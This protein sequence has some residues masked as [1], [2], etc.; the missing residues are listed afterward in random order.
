[1]S[2]D[3]TDT[4]GDPMGA[5]FS[6]NFVVR[7]GVWSTP[8]ELTGGAGAELPRVGADPQGNAVAVWRAFDDTLGNSVLA[9]SFTSAQ[10]WTTPEPLDNL[11]GEPIFDEPPVLLSTGGD[12]VAAWAQLL[13]ASRNIYTNRLSGGA[14]GGPSLRSDG[15]DYSRHTP[16]LT[17]DGGGNLLLMWRPFEDPFDALLMAR[18]VS[19]TG[20]WTE[21]DDILQVQIA[22]S[23]FGP[24]LTTGANG[25]AALG[26]HVDGEPPTSRRA[27]VSFF[28]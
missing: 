12:F 25:V 19:G 11:D 26:F 15:F 2:G 16:Q 22:P 4:D 17:A 18:Y 9:P 14:W 23:D 6:S 13:D 24:G 10:G 5:D 21:G 20:T 8:E 7:D 3:V 1:M 27:K 28:E